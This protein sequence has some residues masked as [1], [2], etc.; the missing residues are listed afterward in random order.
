MGLLNKEKNI[1]GSGK[2]PRTI[3]RQHCGNCNTV[4]ALEITDKLGF[5][6]EYWWNNK[7]LWIKE[8]WFG[9]QFVCP[10]CGA[11]GKLPMDKPLSYEQIQKNKESVNA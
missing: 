9:N 1:I 3:R 10:Q 8:R 2:R 6:G 11:T 7:G 5:G 4:L